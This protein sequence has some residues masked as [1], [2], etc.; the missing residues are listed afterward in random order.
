MDPSRDF[1]SQTNNSIHLC[2]WT[3]NVYYLMNLINRL[4]PH[5]T[6]LHL[7]HQVTHGNQTRT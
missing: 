5:M 6:Y 7:S 1:P 3:P 2:T 4:A